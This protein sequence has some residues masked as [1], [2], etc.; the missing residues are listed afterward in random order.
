MNTDNR[1]LYWEFPNQQVAIRKG[2]W[3]AVSVKK[4]ADLELYDMEKDPFEK[5]N[6][7][8]QYPK[9]VDELKSEIDKS[10]TVS[11]YYE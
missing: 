9:I 8:Q 10:R 11:L 3:K 1:I 4:N 2:K 5:N 6:L 7:A